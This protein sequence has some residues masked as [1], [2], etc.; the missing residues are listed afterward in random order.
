LNSQDFKRKEFLK[1]QIEGY[2]SLDGP[3]KVYS[4]F[5][6]ERNKKGRAITNSALVL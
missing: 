6:I 5:T 2:L 4:R 1:K 3:S